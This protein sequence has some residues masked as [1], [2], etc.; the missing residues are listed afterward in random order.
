MSLV[1]LK[2]EMARLTREEQQ[3]LAAHLDFILRDG[4]PEYLAELNRR[5]ERI[6]RGQKATEADFLAAHQRLLAEGK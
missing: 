4:D 5:A 1:Q 3:A 6:E 2:S